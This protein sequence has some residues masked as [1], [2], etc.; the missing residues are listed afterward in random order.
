MCRQPLEL[1]DLIRVFKPAANSEAPQDEKEETQPHTTATAEAHAVQFIAAARRQ[2]YSRVRLPPHAPPMRN[3]LYP[4]LCVDG[5]FFL[6]HL[7]VARQHRSPKVK[8][9]LLALHAVFEKDST[10][11]VVIFSQVKEALLHVSKVFDEDRI[12]HNR[13]IPGD[14]LAEREAAVHGFVKDPSCRVLLLHAGVAA[15]GLTLTVARHVFLL[16]PFLSIGDE[17]QAMN[18]CHRIGQTHDVRVYTFYL[19]G[20]VEERLLAYRRLAEEGAFRHHE[21]ADAM[22]VLQEE[23]KRNAEDASEALSVIAGEDG[24]RGRTKN[25][26]KHKMRFLF[27]LDDGLC[28]VQEE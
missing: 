5:G 27:G 9:L 18:R 25:L 23:Q 2:D 6:G 20:T 21:C 26:D 1:D 19:R 13:I 10:N 28:A 22:H 24:S 3:G 8:A 12:G 15:A 4:A 11:K 14:Q 16:E 17:L 7:Q